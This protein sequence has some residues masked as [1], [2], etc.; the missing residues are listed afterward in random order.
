MYYIKSRFEFLQE[1]LSLSTAKKYRKEWDENK[2]KDIFQKY[3][4]DPRAYRIYLP[5]VAAK[6]EANAPPQVDNFL[7]SIGW[8]VDDYGLGLAKEKSTGRAM[9]IGKLINKYGDSET[10]KIFTGGPGRLK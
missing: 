8:G 1:G 9:K 5:F 4:D 2:W 10:L 3:T 7:N 6:V